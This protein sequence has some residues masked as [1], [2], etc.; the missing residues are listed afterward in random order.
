MTS[1]VN[2]RND[3][4]SSVG[5]SYGAGCCNGF[6][7]TGSTVS[8]TVYSDANMVLTSLIDATL[9]QAASQTTIV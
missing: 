4:V 1:S 9:C 3:G 2:S 8:T 6:G 5:L 7:P